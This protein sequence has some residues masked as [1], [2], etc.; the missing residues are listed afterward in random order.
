MNP[1]S[2]TL[3]P[4]AILAK[5]GEISDFKN[6]E[7][8]IML[9]DYNKVWDV[10]SKLG[11]NDQ[12]KIKIKSL[13]DKVVIITGSGNGLGKSHALWFAKYG[14]KVVVNDFKDPFSVVEE[15]RKNGGTAVASKHDVYSEADKIVKTALIT[16]ELWIV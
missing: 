13:K 2:D 4:E 11:K 9:K 16:S 12:G 6:A 7:Y 8:P 3:T 1:S 10:T 14:A 15:I 5:F